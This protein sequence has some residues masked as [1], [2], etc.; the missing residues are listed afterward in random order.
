MSA[1]LTRASVRSVT[2]S[3]E[4]LLQSAAALFDALR[5]GAVEPVISARYPLSQ[6][7]E[8]HV[9]LETRRTTG[10]LILEP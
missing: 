8:A 3:R 2:E 6:A 5:T 9:A 10:S 4:T 1:Y 7:A